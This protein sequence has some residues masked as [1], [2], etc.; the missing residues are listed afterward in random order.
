M[1]PFQL[2]AYAYRNEFGANQRNRTSGSA[3][4]IENSAC[5]KPTESWG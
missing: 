2:S 1:T 5:Q 3:K 4:T